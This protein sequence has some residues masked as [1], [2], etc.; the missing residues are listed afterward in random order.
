MPYEL[1]LSVK[2]MHSLTN[3]MTFHENSVSNYQAQ[4]NIIH[5]CKMNYVLAQSSDFGFRSTVIVPQK[6]FRM[7]GVVG[8]HGKWLE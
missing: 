7:V 3:G 4:K 6:S 8:G 5:E 2:G 1:H